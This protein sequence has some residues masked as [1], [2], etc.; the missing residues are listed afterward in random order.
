MD[1]ARSR[2]RSAG[3]CLY[4]GFATRGGTALTGQER[5]KSGGIRGSSSLT[6]L[7]ARFERIPPTKGG[8][9]QRESR[10]QSRSQRRTSW[11]AHLACIGRDNR[12]ER[13][14]QSADELSQ[15]SNRAIG[16]AAWC[17]CGERERHLPTASECL[18]HKPKS[19]PRASR[20]GACSATHETRDR[21]E[22][23]S[24]SRIWQSPHWLLNRR[25]SRQPSRFHP[26]AR[27][28]HGG[29]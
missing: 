20:R 18:S 2:R 1:K 13:R 24:K 22:G 4:R 6:R 27:S 29:Q 10:P 9:R 15:F 3:V 17:R 11:S 25:R 19:R 12:A 8:R 26:L 16:R 23:S 14:H 7:L 28:R 5:L 21:G